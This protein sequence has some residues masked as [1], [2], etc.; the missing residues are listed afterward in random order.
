MKLFTSLKGKCD[1]YKPDNVTPYMHIMALH[2]PEVIR[3][4]KNLYR[5]SCQG[6]DS[7]ICAVKSLL[8][9]FKNI[10]TEKKNDNAKKVF[11]R[12]SNKWDAAR[13][14]LVHEYR[15]NIMNYFERKKRQ[16][17]YEK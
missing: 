8:G 7:L 15:L 5:F 2:M 13:D 17:R 4:H 11:F 10:G 14:I 6:I 9:F 3:R 12:S 16:Y 1:G